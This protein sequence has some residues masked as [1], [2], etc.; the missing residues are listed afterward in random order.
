[1]AAE[2]AKRGAKRLF[3]LGRD[4]MRLRESAERCIGC[5]VECIVVDVTDR[6][7]MRET[8]ERV[9]REC[10]LDVVIANAGVATGQENEINARHTFEV[11]I[12]GV[13]NTVFPAIDVFTARRCGKIVIVSSM[14]AY[15][16]MASCPSYAASKAAV[17]AWGAGLRGMLRKQGI[18]VCVVCP[19]FVRSGITDKNDFRM[20]FFMEADKA[21]RIIW[22]GILRNSPLI[23]FPWQMR[24]A[25]W[26]G[27]MLPEAIA[28]KLYSR[29]PKK[30][31]A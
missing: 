20:P 26:L 19:G 21:A 23:A 18:D 16:G 4:A 1:M 7:L 31:T 8:I 12:G 6:M 2:A 5:E 11:N 28:D 9:A 29:L 14:T 27:A 24:F 10:P 17:K 25:A 30:S 3:L 13:A 22:R 15:H